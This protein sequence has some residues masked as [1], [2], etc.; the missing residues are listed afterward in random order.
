M[1]LILFRFRVH[2]RWPLMLVANRDEAY[3]RPTQP[4]H[5]WNHKPRLLAGKDLKSGG[6]WLGITQTGRFA[7]IA[8]CYS[9]TTKPQASRGRLVRDFLMSDATPKDAANY[10][11][12][13][14]HFYAG[15][16]LLLGAFGANKPSLYYVSNGDDALRDLTPGTYALGNRGLNSDEPRNHL[17]TQVFNGH[18]TL[19][20]Q[21]LFALMRQDLGAPD[22]H[23][24]SAAFL[25][26]ISSS[27]FVRTH[28]YGTRTTAILQMRHNCAKLK[29]VDYYRLGWRTNV[30]QKRLVYRS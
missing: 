25:K 21:E 13:K 11:Q 3:G 30:T 16:S 12:R 9:V 29:W 27:P 7:A 18:N 8:N 1:C 19:T 5:F 24:K 6:T 26:Y 22:K 14:G 23:R 20:D 28:N 10:I 2:A 17:L 15:F 4:P